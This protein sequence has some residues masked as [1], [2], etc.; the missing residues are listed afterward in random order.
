ML[1]WI[2]D[3]GHKLEFYELAVMEAKVLYCILASRKDA[4]VA[5]LT[6]MPC[7]TRFAWSCDHVSAPRPVAYPSTVMAHAERTTAPVVVNTLFA[8]HAA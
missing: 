7:A 6:H 2:G 5:P 4:H 1:P 8:S 3:I